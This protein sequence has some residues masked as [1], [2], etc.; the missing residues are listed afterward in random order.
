MEKREKHTWR[1]K[2]KNILGKE[3]Y[4]V[5]YSCFL[6]LSKKCFTWSIKHYYYHLF[7][8]HSFPLKPSTFS[9]F[10]FCQYLLSSL[11]AFIISWW[12]TQCSS[13]FFFIL[14][15][16]FSEST[17]GRLIT[18]RKISLSVWLTTNDLS[19]GYKIE[20]M[21]HIAPKIIYASVCNN[22]D[23]DNLNICLSR[24]SSDI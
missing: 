20:S 8:L 1:E 12:S 24:V 15:S 21:F 18:L 9:K 4:L 22:A 10:Y 17:F 3:V 19:P 13:R 7:L 5:W 14:A 11:N 2:K 23:I 16:C 6:W